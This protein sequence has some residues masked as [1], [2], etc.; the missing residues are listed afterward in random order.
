MGTSTVSIL[1]ALSVG[2]MTAAATSVRTVSWI[3]LRHWAERQIAGDTDQAAPAL[4]RPHRFLLA[5]GTGIAAVVFSLG[6]TLAFR[7]DDWALVRA[8]V[9]AT[10]LLLVLG[11]LV[12]RAIARRSATTLIPALM[13]LLRALDALFG[14]ILAFAARAVRPFVHGAVQARV[15]EPRDPL[16]DLLREAEAEGLGGAADSEIISG[17][18]EFGEKRV[19]DVMTPRARVTSVA[20]DAPAADIAQ[21]VG[22][23]QYTRVP[24]LG[25][26]AADAAG[27]VHAFD[28]LLHPE[29]PLRHLRPCATATVDEPCG[30]AMRR[31]MREH[32]HL[33]VVRD[34]AGAVVGIVTLEDLVEELVGDIRDEHDEPGGV[35]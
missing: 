9:S 24:V 17:V 23:S 20:P 10:L 30:V 28:V 16:E 31:M 6:A 1:F 11:Q 19:G 8:L 3:W 27:I 21:V 33:A 7:E 25:P 4:G 2:L 29:D 26:G 35:G 14:P 22:A 15:P 18:V 34:A 5:A 12:P 32:R 13:P